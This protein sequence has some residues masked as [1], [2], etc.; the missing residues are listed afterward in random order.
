MRVQER[1]V[2]VQ[3]E[4][5]LVGVPSSF[6]RVSGCNLRCAWCDSP[7]TSWAPVGSSAKVEELVRW[8]L[9]GP[10]HVVVTGGEPLLFGAV[11]ELVHQLRQRD[12]HVTVE[13]AGSVWLDGLACDLVSIS[14][15]L[16]H[17]TPWQ[18]DSTWAAR[19]EA[20]RHTPR[21]VRRLMD[22]FEW[23]LKFVVASDNDHQLER[24]LQEIEDYLGEIALTRA[25]R[26]RVFLMP[27]GT[28]PQRLGR[29]YGKLAPLCQRTGFRLAPRLHIHAFGHRPGT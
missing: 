21:T 24:D 23:Q 7:Q 1:F 4:G 2:S 13:T 20:R 16:A 29:A 3:G 22:A 14:P 28:D 8:A 11:A 27:E 26:W 6:V 17:S 18:R 10:R 5:A 19:H 25:E 9:G 15:K 12:H